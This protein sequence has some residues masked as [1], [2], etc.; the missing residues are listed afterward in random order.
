MTFRKTEKDVLFTLRFPVREQLIMLA[1]TAPESEME[2]RMLLDMVWV[3]P[4]LE[5]G[6][7][8][9]GALKLQKP[10]MISLR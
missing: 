5:L 8:E 3:S 10:S 4:S 1:R 7:A 9:F 2:A 6:K